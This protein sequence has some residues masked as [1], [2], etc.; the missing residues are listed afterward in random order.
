MA[1]IRREV[2]VTASP[3]AVWAVVRDYG[4]AHEK[5]FPGVLTRI[6]LEEGARVVTFANGMVVREFIVDLDDQHRRFAWN[7]VGGSLTHHNGALQVFPDGR[8]GSRVTWVTD[9]LPD[10]ATGPISGLVDAG[11]AA[12]TT[13]LTKL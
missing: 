10:A 11:T 9:F 4:T 6:E 3:E 12:M 8:G 1:S 13:A 5:L 7:A 2:R